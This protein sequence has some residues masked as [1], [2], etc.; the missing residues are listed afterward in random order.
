M[1]LKTVADTWPIIGDQC[2]GRFAISIFWNKSL[3][4]S[5][6][7]RGGGGAVPHFYINVNQKSNKI[8]YSV[9][10]IAEK[11][12]TSGSGYEQHLQFL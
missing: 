7:L 3:F 8:Q 5:K 2:F 10:S 9:P 6:I 11:G 4:S 1:Q 12:T